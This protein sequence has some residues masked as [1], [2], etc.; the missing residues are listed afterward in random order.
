MVPMIVLVVVTLIA[1][2]RVPWKDAVRI[3]MA[4]LLLFTASAH[5]N[6]MKHVLAAMIPPPLTGS[7]WL[8]YLTGMLEISGA[9][10]LLIPRFRKPAALCLVLLLIALFPANVYAALN[11]VTL[12]GRPRRR[13]GSAR[14]CRSS[15]SQRCGGRRFGGP[16][17]DRSSSS[18]DH[19]AMGDRHTGR[20]R[21]RVRVGRHLTHGAVHRHWLYP[22]ARRRRTK[23]FRCFASRS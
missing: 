9:V 14:R 16:W 12:R 7:L 8:I 13:S 20:R 23:S 4:A 10:G 3:G 18:R 17:R 19:A 2:A 5:F 21:H 15:G 11:G 6:A 22:H 1:R